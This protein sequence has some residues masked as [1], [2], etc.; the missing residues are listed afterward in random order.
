MKTDYSRFWE[1]VDVRQD[2]ECWNW[3]TPT[4]NNHSPS[5]FFEGKH[6]FASI[7]SWKIHFGE[8]PKGL[9]ICHECDNA[10]CVN[11]LHLWLGTPKDNMADL[12][13]K[14]K[15]ETQFRLLEGRK[16][17]TRSDYRTPLTA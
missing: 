12:A 3:R 10:N 14:V 1:K 7:V 11:P 13:E 5:F 15:L 4:K 17:A 16:P 9:F 2:D 6:S 8:V